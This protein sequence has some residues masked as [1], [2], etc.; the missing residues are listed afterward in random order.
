MAYLFYLLSVFMGSVYFLFKLRQVDWLAVAFFSSIAYY[1]PALFGY[2]VLG[3]QMVAVPAP[4]YFFLGVLSLS[5]ALLGMLIDR[6]KLKPVRFVPIGRR[7]DYMAFHSL[8]GWVF[9]FLGV[10][11]LALDVSAAGSALMS[12]SKVTVAQAS[13]RWSMVWTNSHFIS[14][15]IGILIRSRLL[16]SLSFLSLLLSVAIGFRVFFVLALLAG[17]AIYLWRFGRIRL[18][19]TSL[20]I[21]IAVLMS[22]IFVLLYKPIYKLI[23]MGDVSGIMEKLSDPGMLFSALSRNEAASRVWIISKTYTEKVSLSAF[24]HYLSVVESGLMNPF[25]S[26]N[27]RYSFGDVAKERLAAN[28]DWGIASN[29]FAEILATLSFAGLIVASLIYGLLIFLISVLVRKLGAAAMVYSSI[30]MVHI[31]FYIH[32]NDVYRLLSFMVKQNLMLLISGVALAGI[33]YLFKTGLSR[34]WQMPSAASKND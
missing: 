15:V 3:G 13:T 20:K 28:V 19:F 32:R 14:F 17:G 29:F 7:F 22:V 21:N 24:E 11:G 31:T 16:V 5:L 23:K 33:V 25:T 30:F 2:G 4:I 10:G 9:L 1:Y 12:P 26:D 27:V 6:L 18:A 8:L 34:K